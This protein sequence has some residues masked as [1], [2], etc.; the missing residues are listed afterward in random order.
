MTYYLESKA[1]L[2][3][4]KGSLKAGVGVGVGV[5]AGTGLATASLVGEG[6]KTFD[7]VGVV[8]GGAS[9]PTP[10]LGGGSRNPLLPPGALVLSVPSPFLLF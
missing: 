4:P 7:F 10:P 2:K 5:G 8:G 1:M 9:M 3:S 6:R